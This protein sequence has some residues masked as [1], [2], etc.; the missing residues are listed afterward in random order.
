MVWLD[1]SVAARCTELRLL[2]GR[3]KVLLYIVLIFGTAGIVMN[4]FHLE[5][6]VPRAQ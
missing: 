3:T 5:G 2:L 6:P 4:S 1:K